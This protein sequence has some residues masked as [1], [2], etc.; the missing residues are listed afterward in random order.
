M[1]K[2]NIE[3]VYSV[4]YDMMDSLSKL[5]DQANELIQEVGL[6]SGEIDRVCKEQMQA[7]F[8][9]TISKLKSDVNT[10]GCIKGILDFLDQI[11]L[12]ATRVDPSS[13]EYGV[14]EMDA[15][16]SIDPS[17]LPAS[18]SVDQTADIP[19]NASYNNPQGNQAVET[20]Q[21]PNNPVQESVLKEKHTKY[22]IKR[23][24]IE[25][26]ALGDDVG[27]IEPHIVNEY[28]TKAEAEIACDRLN[29]GVLPS[30]K[31][32]LGTEYFVDTLEFGDDNLLKN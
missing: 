30:E 31:E 9:P 26:S 29:K 1:P 10:P 27:N 18:A 19:M 17:S 16:E 8:L 3:N 7:Y 22:C 11:P 32:I 4:L 13:A 12:K 21:T 15:S 6:F 14:S 23:R 28:N 24:G 5:E 25:N 20:Q 2:K